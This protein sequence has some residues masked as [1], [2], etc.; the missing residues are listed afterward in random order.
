[1]YG[2]QPTTTYRLAAW[3]RV[4]GAAVARL[5]VK[6][7]GGDETRSDG[8]ALTDYGELSLKFTTGT[9]TT[10][11]TVYCWAEGPGSAFFDDVALEVCAQ[12]H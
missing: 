6:D 1:M 7:H 3:A 12:A 9:N 4:S 5:G 10:R 2:L 8:L 11:A